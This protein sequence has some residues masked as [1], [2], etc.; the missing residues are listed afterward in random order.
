MSDKPLD[1]VLDLFLKRYLRQH[2]TQ[3]LPINA[4]PDRP[5]RFLV[6]SSTAVGDTILSTP[7]IRSLRRSF[8]ESTITA[9][10]HKRVAPLFTAFPYLDEIIVFHGGYK[11]FIPTAKKI[12]ARRPETALIFHGN[13]PQDIALA[14]FSGARHILKHPTRSGY[15]KY[16]SYDFESRFQHAV[17]ERLDL[18]RKIGGAQIDTTL[19]IPPIPEAE[20]GGKSSILPASGKVWIG[21]Q[22]GAANV[23]KMWPIERF[24]SL[25]ERILRS[26]PNVSIVITGNQKERDLAQRISGRFADRVLNTC[27]QVSI[28]EWP[29]LIKQLRLLITNDTGTLHLAVAL[30]TP[31]LSLFSATDSQRIGPYQDPELHRVIQKDGL[32]VQ[33]FPKEKRTDE[34]MRLIT[35]DE[36]YAVYEHIMSDRPV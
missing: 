7:A 10:L 23:Y 13:G 17:E 8:P 3:I 31:T 33:Q 29:S 34:A 18:V 35:V 32:L 30:K 5:Q 26:D 1:R 15:K 36:V 12:R 20:T 14:V 25:A 22:I 2:P 19:E 11:R 9:L 4:L 28:R 21:F 27:G 24:L 6:I 16:L